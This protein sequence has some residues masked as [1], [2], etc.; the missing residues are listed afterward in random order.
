M[1]IGAGGCRGSHQR[2]PLHVLATGKELAADV[3][4]EGAD[5]RVDDQMP[6][7]GAA[8]LGDVAT[9]RALQL[10]LCHIRGL[11]CRT[12]NGEPLRALDST[13]TPARQRHG[14]RSLC[15]ETAR[16]STHDKSAGNG[17]ARSQ[18]P[19]VTALIFLSKAE[20]C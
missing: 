2:M 19:A 17:Y 14:H 1:P 12:E 5:A 16:N 6:L 13:G 9:V 18:K 10:V 11:A 3:T 20:C 15:G 4:A 7:E 8:V